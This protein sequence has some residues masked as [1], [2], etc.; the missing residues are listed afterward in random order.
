MGQIQRKL[1]LSTL[2][3]TAENQ[4]LKIKILKA[5]KGNQHIHF[6]EINNS[7]DC[8]FLIKNHGRQ[9]TDNPEFYIQQKH[10]SVIKATGRHV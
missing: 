6:K 8:K 2:Y 3:K 5:A 7:N 10:L 9:K 4:R 1:C